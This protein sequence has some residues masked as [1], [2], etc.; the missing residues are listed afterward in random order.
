MKN[1]RVKIHYNKQILARGT[2]KEKFITAYQKQN[3]KQ[4]I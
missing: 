3:L 2:L 4:D 1:A